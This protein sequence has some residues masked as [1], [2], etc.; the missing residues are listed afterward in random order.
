MSFKLK[1]AMARIVASTALVLGAMGAAEAAYIHADLVRAS[2]NTWDAS[3]TVG[4]DPGQTLEAFSIYFDWTQVSNLM[5]QAAPGDWDVLALQGDS[6]LA[7]DGIFDALALAGG[8]TSGSSLGEFTTRFDWADPAGPTQ[9]R[10]SI[11]DPVTFEAL[12]AGEVAL[13]DGG[14]GGIT[15]PEPA[16]WALI[17]LAIGGL[18]AAG[19]NCQRL[20]A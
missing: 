8:I 19:R 17:V 18:A 5:V 11:N 20:N 6:G 15:V 3:F 7:S 2:G 4:A 14:G 10:Y 13:G 1:R 9:L 12:E 16:S